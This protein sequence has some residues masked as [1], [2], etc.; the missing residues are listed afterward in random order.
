MSFFSTFKETSWGRQ[1]EKHS[2]G[3]SPYIYIYIYGFFPVNFVGNFGAF[4]SL[5][6]CSSTWMAKIR[7][8]GFLLDVKMVAFCT[9]FWKTPGV[10]REFLE[11]GIFNVHNFGRCDRLLSI[12]A[13]IWLWFKNNAAGWLT[14]RAHQRDVKLKPCDT[15]WW[16][17]FLAKMALI[18]GWS[19]LLIPTNPFTTLP[20][21]N[22]A[23]HEVCATTNK[24]CMTFRWSDWCIDFWYNGII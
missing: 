10:L 7:I 24:N 5:M 9:P 19:H 16:E 2:S 22:P 6:E 4:N 18:K 20:F 13:V 11:F 12:I 17:S 14:I 23:K 1:L 8:Y 3:P 21:L 15:Q